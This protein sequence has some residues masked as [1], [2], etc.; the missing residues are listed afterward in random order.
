MCIRDSNNVPYLFY[1]D[2]NNDQDWGVSSASQGDI[3]PAWDL[4]YNHYVNLKGLA[5]PWSQQYAAL[6]R[7][8]GGGGNYG[9][10]SG[11]YDQLGFTTLTLSL[12]HI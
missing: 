2:C 9:S 8:E 5:A 10:T 4:I 11:G 6:V 12:I 3:R 7:P 1:D